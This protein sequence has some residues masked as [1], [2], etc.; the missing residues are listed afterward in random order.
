MTSAHPGVAART[1]ATSMARG[2]PDS[3]LLALM[4]PAS[5]TLA[6]QQYAAGAQLFQLLRADARV[7]EI[8]IC[9]RLDDRRSHH[10]PREPLVVCGDYEPRRM[11]R[12]GCPNGLLIGRHVVR[13]EGALAHI[14]RREL[15]MLVRFVEPAEESLLLLA[16]RHVQEEL[17][18]DQTLMAQVPLEMRDVG[19]SLLPDVL[20]RAGRRQLLLLEDV[21]MHAYDQDLLVVRAVENADMPTRG[22]AP[23]VPPEEIVIEIR[24][25]GLLERE[26]LAALRVETRHD[27][28]D[29]AVLPCGVHDL[30]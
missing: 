25:R 11:F 26:N 28:L 9:E 24:C 16:A 22:E 20:A 14:G 19:Q 2:T 12:G 21:L 7:C 17:E 18:H 29:G 10:E 30:K 6:L 8:E 13:P 27:M 15:P 5:S 3:S 23:D 4:L 1:A